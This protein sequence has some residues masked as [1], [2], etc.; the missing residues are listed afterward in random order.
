MGEDIVENIAQV[1]QKHA[2][3][4]GV[5]VMHPSTC[6]ICRPSVYH[7]NLEIQISK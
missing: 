3:E 1:N 5:T 2:A 7:D 4:Q 6:Y